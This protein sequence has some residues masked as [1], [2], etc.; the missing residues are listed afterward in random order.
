MTKRSSRSRFV[1]V[2]WTEMATCI[3]G[4][5]VRTSG[6]N[7][8]LTVMTSQLWILYPVT[9]PHHLQFNSSHH[10]T[11]CKNLFSTYIGE[12]VASE[13]AQCIS[14][15]GA[16]IYSDCYNRYTKWWHRICKGKDHLKSPWE[17]FLAIGPGH[18]HAYVLRPGFLF[19]FLPF[20]RL[21]LESL[22][23]RSQERKTKTVPVLVS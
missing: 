4:T 9:L 13:Q 14:C 11:K 2:D 19:C 23:I 1:V 17:K 10:L 18:L 16:V 7:G 5:L 22:G 6:C 8:K 15:V 12:E 20:V 21:N 3:Q